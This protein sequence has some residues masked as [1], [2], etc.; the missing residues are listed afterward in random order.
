MGI[1]W[2]KPAIARQVGIPTGTAEEVGSAKEQSQGPSKARS[3]KRNSAGHPPGVA[4][5]AMR[6]NLHGDSS[7]YE[8]ATIRGIGF[9]FAKSNFI[10]S[11]TAL[12]RV[13]LPTSHAHERERRTKSYRAK[14]PEA[15]TRASARRRKRQQRGDSAQLAHSAGV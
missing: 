1:L 11:D 10:S 12:R 7:M 6:A 13:G 9:V 3:H 5:A 14:G 8:A 2:V 15:C 4:L